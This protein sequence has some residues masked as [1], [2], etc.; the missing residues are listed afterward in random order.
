MLVDTQNNTKQ[1]DDTDPSGRHFAIAAD[2]NSVLLLAT[3]KDQA[4]NDAVVINESGAYPTTIAA[5][6]TRPHSYTPLDGELS[7]FVM[8]PNSDEW[9]KVFVYGEDLD[10][11][12][13]ASGNTSIEDSEWVKDLQNVLTDHGISIGSNTSPQTRKPTRGT[14]SNVDAKILA[15]V[16]RFQTHDII[17]LKAGSYTKPRLRE[18]IKKRIMAG[19]KGGKAGQWSARKAQMLAQEYARQGGGYKGKPK[20]SQ[21]SLKKWTSEEWTTSD[22]EPAIRKGGTNRYLPKKAW[23]KLSPGERAATNRKKRAASKRGEQFVANTRKARRAG[24]KVRRTVVKADGIEVLE[25]KNLRRMARRV[26]NVPNVPKPGRRRSWVPSTERD[27]D[28]DG[29]RVNPLTG[30][31][32]IPV[33]RSRLN[34]N[35]NDPV[36]QDMMRELGIEPGATGRDA[37]RRRAE[38]NPEEFDSPRRNPSARPDPW[39]GMST[40]P[41]EIERDVEDPFDAPRTNVRLEG[42]RASDFTQL[43][44]LIAANKLIGLIQK[45]DLQH[46][47]R[48]RLAR[49]QRALQNLEPKAGPDSLYLELNAELVKRLYKGMQTLK[50]LGE[51]DSIDRGDRFYEVIRDLH[52]GGLPLEDAKSA[53]WNPSDYVVAETKAFK[54]GRRAGRGIRR[55]IDRPRWDG[56]GDNMITNPLTGRDE[57]PWNPAKETAEEAIERFMRQTPGGG[58]RQRRLD[59]IIPGIGQRNK[60]PQAT[61]RDVRPPKLRS[62]TGI[63]DELPDG[64]DELLDEDAIIPDLFTPGDIPKPQGLPIPMMRWREMPAF[65]QLGIVQSLQ[66]GDIGEM[67][68]LIETWFAQLRPPRR[69]STEVV[70]TAR[71]LLLNDPSI[72]LRPEVTPPLQQLD[73]VVAELTDK[74]GGLISRDDFK[75]AFAQ[76]LSGLNAKVKIKDVSR[77]DPDYAGDSDPLTD[78]E[79]AS[80]LGHLFFADRFPEVFRDTRMS[81][82]REDRFTSDDEQDIQIGAQTSSAP[83]LKDSPITLE[84]YDTYKAKIVSDLA[85]EYD[86]MFPAVAAMDGISSQM[87]KQFLAD[88]TDGLD[89]DEI[90]SGLIRLSNFWTAVHENVHFA[91]YSAARRDVAKTLEENNTTFVEETFRRL[92]DPEDFKKTSDAAFLYLGA[93]LLENDLRTA[94]LLVESQQ[95][96]QEMR[97]MRAAVEP[98]R[99][100]A[101]EVDISTLTPEQAENV[102]SILQLASDMDDEI[103]RNTELV[104]RATEEVQKISPLWTPGIHQ[105]LNREGGRPMPHVVAVIGFDATDELSE[106]GRNRIAQLTNVDGD[107]LTDPAVLLGPTDMS[108]VME[109]VGDLKESLPD[110]MKARLT[111]GTDLSLP[112]NADIKQAAEDYAE[113]LALEVQLMHYRTALIRMAQSLQH[114]EMLRDDLSDE[115]WKQLSKTWK[116]VSSY[117][118]DRNSFYG[119]SMGIPVS[120][121][122]VA[123]SISLILAGGK[124]DPRNKVGG[125]AMMNRFMNWLG[126]I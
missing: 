99:Q 52:R 11:N 46:R 51:L 16:R 54:F 92:T 55:L 29:F 75:R 35:D 25:M 121:E 65:V 98:S 84:L 4:G 13:L 81:I 109:L 41:R 73:A 27:G 15:S 20:K 112:E 6:L 115:E 42:V 120:V 117:A 97:S 8:S 57:I 114:M 9:E 26:S 116:Y 49:L 86:P 96:L 58:R 50:Q 56:D 14:I 105:A 24:A 124:V 111:P 80:L 95:H 37:R 118:K 38:F 30:R 23:A 126:M 108:E 82:T 43:E 69:T 59:Q 1:K 106:Y 40:G 123:E 22:G 74:Y 48:G 79:F 12:L 87:Q 64:D 71:R 119:G 90:A 104:A 102:Q 72:K 32:D 18:A 45:H 70:E 83:P 28:G 113:R 10:E 53:N 5:Q 125:D 19:D 36:W 76:A 67:G 44:L 66:Q 47:E 61:L 101:S 122:G 34:N 100:A 103:Q 33:L 91:H 93:D 89:D 88:G 62:E 31:D 63:P 94:M 77:R 107:A 110:E 2:G 3:N 68:Q 39:A 85:N 78:N 7:K 60:K 17:E 21:R